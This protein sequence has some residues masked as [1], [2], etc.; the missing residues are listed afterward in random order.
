M[1]HAEP[2]S[3]IEYQVRVGFW[4]AIRGTVLQLNIARLRQSARIATDTASS[5]SPGACPQC[6]GKGQITQTSGRMKFNVH[7]PRCHG[8][9]KNAPCAACAAAKAR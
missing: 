8:T 1:Q 7:C 4:D 3:D 5:T 2:G 9:G 6:G